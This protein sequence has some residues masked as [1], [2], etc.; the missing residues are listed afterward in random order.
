MFTAIDPYL[1][2]AG[3][4]LPGMA[5]MSAATALRSW[6]QARRRQRTA[7]RQITAL[8]PDGAIGQQAG[9]AR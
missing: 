9:G 7:W 1:V 2:A 5:Y 3:V 4:L 8:R 6:R